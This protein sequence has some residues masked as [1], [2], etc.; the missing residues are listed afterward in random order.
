MPTL[1]GARSPDNQGGRMSERSSA[2]PGRKKALRCRVTAGGAAIVRGFRPMRR[3]AAEGVGDFA[4][5]SRASQAMRDVARSAAIVRALVNNPEAKLPSARTRYN[6]IRI[7][8]EA[9]HVSAVSN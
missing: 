8:G 5:V 6:E 3:I 9:D 7:R 4:L 2:I 1:R